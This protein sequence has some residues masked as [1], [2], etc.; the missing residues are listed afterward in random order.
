MSKANCAIFSA[1]KRPKGICLHICS[2]LSIIQSYDCKQ[3]PVGFLHADKMA[4]VIKLNVLRKKSS[5]HPSFVRLSWTNQNSFISSKVQLKWV[6]FLTNKPA[7]QAAGQTLP[8]ATP[9]VGKIHPFS[10]IAVTCEQ[11]QRF[12][13]PSQ[14]RI[15][16]KCQYDWKHHFYAFGHDGVLKIF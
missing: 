2:F 15:S 6:K 16:E 5:Q 3:V 12:G 14:F 13:C 10:K 8:D 9:Q 11:I 4:E 7:A 1:C